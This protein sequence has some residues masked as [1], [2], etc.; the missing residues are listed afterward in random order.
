[1]EQLLRERI[2]ALL[3]PAAAREGFELVAIETG[4]AVN[5]PL[6]RVFLDREGG[7]GI[8]AIVEANRWISSALDEADLVPGSYTLEVSSPGI[9]RP[10]T[11]LD[12]YR[13]FLGETATIKTRQAGS[14]STFRGTIEEVRDDVILLHVQGET[15]H[16]AFCDVVKARLN[17]RV[18]FSQKGAEE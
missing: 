13:R 9:D 7:I 1:M 10:L 3:A 11:T 6:V 18:D 5:S 15:V 4:G 16:I 14:S 8:D 2:E 12:H 17:G